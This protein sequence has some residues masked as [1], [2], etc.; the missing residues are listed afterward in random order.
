MSSTAARQPELCLDGSMTTTCLEG[1]AEVRV[2]RICLMEGAGD[3][4][5]LLAPC[6]CKG[7][8]EF[9]HLGCLR[10]WVKGRLNLG[11]A[12]AGGSYFYRPQLCE[13]CV[14]PYPAHVE[15]AGTAQQHPLV[16]V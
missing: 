7:S 15:V 13:L 1:M 12:G 16:E 5:P 14:A 11:E 6:H 9:V 2:C 3:G 8:I 10:H 4:D